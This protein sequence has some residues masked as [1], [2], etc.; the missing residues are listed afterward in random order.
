MRKLL[1]IMLI[2]AAIAGGIY[3]GYRKGARVPAPR[4]KTLIVHFLDASLGNAIVVRSPDDRFTVID[5]G[6]TETGDDLVAFLKE[7]GAQSLTVVV[8]NPEPER[9]GAIRALMET[10]PLRRLLHG[11]LAGRE[12]DWNDVLESVKAAGIPELVLSAGDLVH[13]GQGVNLEVLS[14]P[15]GL[16]ELIESSSDNNSVIAR[17]TYRGVG[18]MV[19]SRSRVEAEGRLIQ[20]GVPLQSD[21][22][23]VA[24][25]GRTGS[26][27]LELLSLVRP[28]YCIVQVGTGQDKPSSSVM[29]RIS[30]ENTGADVYRTDRDGP[31]DIITDGRTI[32]VVTG[33]EAR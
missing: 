3:V 12:Q 10:F 1:P 22:L 5:P 13:L 11:E 8:T 4:G 9:T 19:T 27:S 16:F 17:V 28:K 26:T 24:R 6:P 25:G 20:S 33:G 7:M 14:P 21:V 32:N 29:R 18:V 30:M 23:V 2:A 31:I 15:K